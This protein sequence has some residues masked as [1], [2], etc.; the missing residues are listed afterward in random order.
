MKKQGR[1]P[2]CAC[3]VALFSVLSATGCGSEVVQSASS[4]SSSEASSPS[5]ASLSPQ[6][7]V[8]GG[9]WDRQRVLDF[10][11]RGL[12]LQINEGDQ[13]KVQ[14]QAESEGAV[15]MD[16]A[17]SSA[18]EWANPNGELAGAVMAVVTSPAHGEEADPGNPE[19]KIIPTVDHG[20]VW[21]V[22]FHTKAP[23]YSDETMAQA[24]MPLDNPMVNAIATAVVD[25]RSGKVYFSN[26]Q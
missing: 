22:S 16:A 25:A 1:L 4:T 3:V 13:E 19:S 8:T 26:L 23:K 5:Q 14:A 7:S 9:D 24:T 6:G 11:Q 12:N 10:A 2:R 20:L 15:A 17:V 21:I 18:R